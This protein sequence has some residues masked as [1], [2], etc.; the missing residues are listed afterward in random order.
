MGFSQSTCLPAASE[1]AHG[2]FALQMHGAMAEYFLDLNR[3]RTM[4]GLKAALARGRK[5]GRPRKLTEKDLAVARAMLKEATIPVAHR[6]RGGGE[7]M[8]REPE[9][10]LRQHL[11]RRR[12]GKAAELAH[13]RGARGAGNGRHV[14]EAPRARRRLH[15]RRDR[16]SRLTVREEPEDAVARGMALEMDAEDHDQQRARQIAGD[17]TCAGRC[18]IELVAD[19]DLQVVKPRN[20]AT[21][22]GADADHLRQRDPDEVVVRLLEGEAAADQLNV[23]IIAVRFDRDGAC[24]LDA[25]RRERPARSPCRGATHNMSA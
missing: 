16:T 9:P 11:E 18:A 13:Q 10:D 7:G 20:R 3:E 23:R 24:H 25:Q 22:G 14:V 12:P 21:I 19:R 15:H 5:G 1:T 2:R 6:L 17:G 8:P 4:E